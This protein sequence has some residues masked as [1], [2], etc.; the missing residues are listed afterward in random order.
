MMVMYL[1]LDQSNRRHEVYLE[2]ATSSV[3]VQREF[4]KAKA[5][6]PHTDLNRIGTSP[7]RPR[8]SNIF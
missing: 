5:D 7:R 1:G 6:T 2:L 8:N 4:L 3:F